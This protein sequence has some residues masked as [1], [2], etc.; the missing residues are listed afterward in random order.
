[1]LSPRFIN[2]ANSRYIVMKNSSYKQIKDKQHMIW[3][4]TIPR[5][6]Q[7]QELHT[8]IPRHPHGPKRQPPAPP[9][10]PPSS[11]PCSPPSRAATPTS[12]ILR[13]CSEVHHVT[14][15]SE[16]I[17]RLEPEGDSSTATWKTSSTAISGCRPD[18]T[19][20]THQAEQARPGPS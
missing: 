9:R 16:G 5:R 6:R 7:H 12:A 11:H 4:L 14:Y 3:A 19:A 15:E 20:G 17:G 2:K 13:P 18:A 1:M 8:P 10:H